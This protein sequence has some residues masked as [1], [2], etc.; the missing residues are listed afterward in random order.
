MLKKL[1]KYELPG[2]FKFLSIF[3]VLSL[4]FSILTRLFLGI[5]NSL[6]ALIIGEIFRGAAISMM[7]SILINNFMRIWVRF[8]QNLY[9]DEAYL[10]HTLPVQ[11]QTVYA[12]KMVTALITMLV[13]LLVIFSSL[14]IMLCTG[15]FME[16]LK[17]VIQSV[18][19]NF[20]GNIWLL[21]AAFVLILFL[22]FVYILQSG[23]TGLIL[24]HQKSNQK[25]GCSV[26]FGFLFYLAGQ[27]VVLLAM[28]I[29]ALCSQEFKAL[30][31][32]NRM[33]GL[34]TIS[35]VLWVCAL[36]YGILIVVGWVANARWLKN[37]VD[38]E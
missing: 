19:E 4:L 3:Y 35:L 14:L 18:I 2:I 22:E 10:T 26:L 28:G 34:K 9:G 24:G 27:L 23:F 6:V 11:K 38:V 36:V 15:S 37:G 25:I 1:L 30:L 33:P 13:S 20:N 31:L 16:A 29:L 8:R 32:S 5:E 12:C 17:T 7:F 21:A